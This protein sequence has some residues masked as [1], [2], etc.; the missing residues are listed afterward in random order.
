MTHGAMAAPAVFV[1]G[2]GRAGVG[3]ARALRA[4]GVT[5]TGVH[6]RRP[7]ASLGIT[8]GR[9]PAGLGG[10]NVALVA[11]R[12]AQIDAALDELLPALP[13]DVI[14]LHL[15]GATEPRTLD[16]IRAKGHAAGTFHPLIPIAGDAALHGAWVGVDGDAAA[17]AASERLASALGAQVLAIPP[18]TK[19]RYHAAAVLASNYP[20]VLAAL[21]D[22]LL[23]EAGI[24]PHAARGAVATLLAAA[25]RN[26]AA[27]PPATSLA[28]ALTGPM[29]RGDHEVVRGHLDALASEPVVAEAYRALAEATVSLLARAEPVPHPAG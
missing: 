3:L 1:L 22:R 24:A 21:A 20:V 2:A 18:G 16:A 7:D 11:V 23:T 28:S 17:R 14:V 12:D 25:A 10:A 19:P 5:V 9:I 26:V 27:A 6:G 13:A 4:A 29:V 15:S 8:A